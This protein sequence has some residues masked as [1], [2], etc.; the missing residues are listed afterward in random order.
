MYNQVSENQVL[1]FLVAKLGIFG[2]QLKLSRSESNPV[3]LRRY[4]ISKRFVQV[5][6]KKIFQEIQIKSKHFVSFFQKN[7]VIYPGLAKIQ[8]STCMIYG[9]YPQN[10]R[11]SC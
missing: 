2:F 8:G 1:M 10:F 11:L 7:G 4:I 6:F 3:S 9:K 5:F